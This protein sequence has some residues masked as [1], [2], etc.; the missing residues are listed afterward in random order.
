MFFTLT[1]SLPFDS[2]FMEEISRKTVELE[3]NYDDTHWMYISDE[4]NN[5]IIQAKDL[6]S[7]LLVKK[8]KRIGVADALKHP[9]IRNRSELKDRIS[10]NRK[11]KFI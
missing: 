2:I 1:G 10:K 6:L 9:W 11:S 3:I 4:V 7:K 5:Y 8:D